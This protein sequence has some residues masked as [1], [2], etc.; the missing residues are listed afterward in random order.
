VY[1]ADRSY[2]RSRDRFSIAQLNQFAIDYRGKFME[3]RLT[4]NLGVRAPEF[5]REL[6][7][8]CYSQNGSTSVLCTTQVPVATLPN[9]N[10][11][12]VNSPTAVEYIAPFQATAKFSEVLPNLGV[13][14]DL[15]STQSVYASYSQGLSA[16]RTDSLYAIKRL[17]DNSL[18][19]ANPNP[20]K[21]DSYDL[22]WRYKSSNFLA[23]AALWQS[24]Y[25]NRIVSSF[26]PDLGFSVDRNIGD[27]DL[28]GADL[29]MAWQPAKWILFNA[30]ASYVKTKLLNDLAIS[31]TLSLPT[32]GKEL[33]E[34][35]KNTY[36]AR[37]ELYPMANL[38]LG[39]QGKLVGKRWSSDLNDAQVDSYKIFDLD[40][41]YN[42]EL[43][44]LKSLSIRANVSNLFDE[45]YYGS[46][47]S[48]NYAVAS[49]SFTSP[50]APFYYIGSPRT[51]S[52]TVQVQF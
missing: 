16:P 34:T 50:S 13:N 35:P 46:I 21:T 33:V 41:R 38:S 24:K 32:A 25:K 18:A 8:Y 23:S 28:S 43:S 31:S 17:A 49:G 44:G 37:M 12:F 20:E 5:K 3:D 4:L 48:T 40:A 14:Y 39:L 26:D 29:Q 30:S 6:N 19:R 51:V 7:Q 27:V 2:L 9:G 52:A 47:S 15:T 45:K 1:T 36:G 11:T 10:V 22:G 42:I